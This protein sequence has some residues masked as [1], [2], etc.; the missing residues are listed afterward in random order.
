M[1]SGTFLHPNIRL[2]CQAVLGMLDTWGRSDLDVIIID[3]FT[4]LDLTLP[5]WLICVVAKVTGCCFMVIIN[6]ALG[7]CSVLIPQ[8]QRDK[9]RAPPQA[10]N[11]QWQWLKISFT[12]LVL[13]TQQLYWIVLQRTGALSAPSLS[14]YF[15]FFFNP[16][17]KNYLLTEIWEIHFFPIRVDQASNFLLIFLSEDQCRSKVL[18]VFR[19]HLSTL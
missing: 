10:M 12:V 3:P 7:Q 11:T 19:V 6:A 18:W 14:V 17:L 5:C 9:N 8:I 15:A 1:H 4:I 16:L 2:A 13:I